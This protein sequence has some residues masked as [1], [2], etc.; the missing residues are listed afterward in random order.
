M[1]ARIWPWVAL[2][3]CLGC[4]S[5]PAGADPR[6]CSALTSSLPAEASTDG[7]AGRYRLQLVASSGP[8]SGGVAAGELE[9]VPYD[10]ASRRRT[11]PLGA[12]NTSTL[13]PLYGSTDVSLDAVGAVAGELG[14]LDPAGPGVLVI[15]MA[16]RSQSAGARVLLRLGVEANRAGRL[17]FDGA[18]TVLR[19]REIADDGF[20]GDWDS[21]APLPRARGHFCAVRVGEVEQ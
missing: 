19:V 8:D 3:L 10:A 12:G 6:P 18:Y 9:L 13:Y 4:R 20:A 5:L 14:S 16:P 11:A 2:G 15:R 7:L 1:N 21:G 17:R